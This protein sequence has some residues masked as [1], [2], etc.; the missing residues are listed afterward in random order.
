MGRKGKWFGAVKKTFTP[1]CCQG[2][3]KVQESKLIEKGD[4]QRKHADSSA[5]AS[6]ADAEAEAAAAAITA[7]AAAEVAVSHL[8]TSATR[9]IGESREEIA[10]VKIQTAYRGYQARRKLRTLRGLVRLKRMLDGNAVKSQTTNT[11]KCMQTLARLQT[12]IHSRRVR[13]IEENQALQRHLQRKH[14]KE[15]ENVKISEQWE[16][17]LQSKEKFEANLL[18]KQDAAIRRERALAYAF[19]HQSRSTSRSIVPT[20][21]DPSNPQWGWSWLERLTATK[22]WEKQSTK[23][24]KDHASMKSNSCT[25][26]AAWKSRRQQSPT[27]VYSRTPSAMSRKKSESP[28]GRRGSIDCDSRSTFSVQSERPRRR[29]IAGSSIRDDES[30]VS[31]FTHPNYM[32]STVS[33]RAKS[34]SPSPACNKVQ[35]P[36]KGWARTAKR[37]LSFSSVDY[38]SSTYAA[39]ARRLSGPPDVGIS[40]LK[41]EAAAGEEQV[42]TSMSMN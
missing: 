7:Q 18:N 33:S 40:P 12:V 13:M 15:L 9:H 1:H 20:F 38:N 8:A 25:P 34:R 22:P 19:T 16:V 29:S 10:A 14:G 6:A 42:T 27:V 31:S 5:L 37:H 26:S 28:R 24:T 4:E 17:S 30:L 2:N 23:E 35:T 36:E 21:T 41:D 3:P 32:A 39:N 11:L